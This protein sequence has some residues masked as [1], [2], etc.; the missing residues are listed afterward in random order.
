MG[1]Q[2]TFTGGRKLKKGPNIKG[3][4]RII[5]LQL[6]KQKEHFSLS[7]I[8]MYVKNILSVTRTTLVAYGGASASL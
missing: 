3:S 7:D 1:E 6:Y 4:T 8:Y 2:Q 5:L